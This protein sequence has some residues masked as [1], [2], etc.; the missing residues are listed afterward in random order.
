MGPRSDPM[1]NL[2]TALSPTPLFPVP[3]PISGIRYQGSGGA[4]RHPSSGLPSWWTRAF[5]LPFIFASL[6]CEA[7]EPVDP[8]AIAPAWRD[9]VS[10]FAV[11][12]ADSARPSLRSDTNGHTGFGL[13][14]GVSRT[15][16]S[17][18]EFRGEV[19]SESV[20]VSDNPDGQSQDWYETTKMQLSCAIH[21]GS[22]TENHTYVFGGGG[23]RY[24]NVG[25][26][27]DVHATTLQAIFGIN[28]DRVTNTR[29]SDLAP[30]LALGCGYQVHH[31]INV[32]IQINAFPYL[33][34]RESGLTTMAGG[35]TERH[36][37]YNLMCGFRFNNLIFLPFIHDKVDP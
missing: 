9:S 26:L 11:S 14:F 3:A 13:Q 10:L 1:L 24:S 8:G 27:V 18:T 23:L 7:C 33:R 12:T 2:E 21:L 22:T 35:P 30:F 20:L 16:A 28:N 6:V 36:I 19:G 15:S 4:T 32:E 17:G 25:H 34:F 5:L 29:L 37:C 31:H